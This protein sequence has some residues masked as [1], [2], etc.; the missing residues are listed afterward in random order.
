[1]RLSIALLALV[2]A[3]GSPSAQRLVE[4]D[5]QA[6][7]GGAEDAALPLAD[8]GEV[9]DEGALDAGVAWD[10]GADAGMRD[11]GTDAGR[12]YDGECT[13]VPQS[14]CAPGEACRL[15]AGAS[16]CGPVRVDALVEGD[17]CTGG[18]L[19]SDC[20]AGLTCSIGN[21]WRFCIPGSA[22]ADLVVPAGT[23][24]MECR[25]TA[26]DGVGICVTRSGM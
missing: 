17:V 23:Y 15:V 4:L 22:C 5:A 6:P 24:A 13:L 3:C 21:C 12:G 16:V 20:A 18:A 11:L 9:L 8:A 25:P 1:M 19:G 26:T 14:G 10:A 2:A 7:D